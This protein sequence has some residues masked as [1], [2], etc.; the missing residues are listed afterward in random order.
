MLSRLFHLKIE[1]IISIVE[2][3]F[4]NP[5][6]GNFYR[7]SIIYQVTRKHVMLYHGLI[8]NLVGIIIE[9]IAQKWFIMY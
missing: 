7:V 9:I 3:L 2:G 1:L 6:L 4:C 8:Y 5:F